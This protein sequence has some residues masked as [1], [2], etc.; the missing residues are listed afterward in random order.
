VT[1]GVVAY[2]LGIMSLDLYLVMLFSAA[3][4]GLNVAVLGWLLKAILKARYFESSSAEMQLT[5]IA[6]AHLYA[7]T[8]RI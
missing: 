6:L 5:L 7:Y 1:L 2:S 4:V 3:L 8:G